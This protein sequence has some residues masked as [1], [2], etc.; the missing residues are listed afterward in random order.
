MSLLK[1]KEKEIQKD[2]SA[3]RVEALIDRCVDD[4]H[5]KPEYQRKILL[6]LT[7]GIET[8]LTLGGVTFNLKVKPI[9]ENGVRLGMYV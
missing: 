5:V 6:E 7:S 8:N 2:V 4:F 3:F 1:S 9:L